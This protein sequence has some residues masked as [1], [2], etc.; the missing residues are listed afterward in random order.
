MSNLE[1]VPRRELQPYLKNN[2]LADKT[3]ETI[4][5]SEVQ[6]RRNFEPYEKPIQISRNFETQ[7]EAENE[8]NLRK[9][10]AYENSDRRQRLDTSST[11]PGS[12][13]S[14]DKYIR[15]DLSTDEYSSLLG[16]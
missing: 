12:T 13:K 4:L 7:P 14:F 15:Y 9:L 3:T 6:N 1:G 8:Q 10:E 5:R 2:I 11:K 16:K